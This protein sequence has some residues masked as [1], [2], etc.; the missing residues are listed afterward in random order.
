MPATT[1]TWA[2]GRPAGGV[3]FIESCAPGGSAQQSQQLLCIA[4][5]RSEEGDGVW[6]QWRD[7]VQGAVLAPVGPEL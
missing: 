7:T 3:L 1:T 6:G 4:R 2:Q 5:G